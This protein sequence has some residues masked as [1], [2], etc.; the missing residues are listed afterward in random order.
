M[1]KFEIGLEMGLLTLDDVRQFLNKELR[2][3]NV[4][5][6]YTD[7]YLSLDKGQ[8]EVINTIFYN[9]Q[10]KYVADR[11]TESPVR[12]MLIGAIRKKWD[13]GKISTEQC[14]KYLEKLNDYFD[15][16]MNCATIGEYYRLN[17]SGS[18]SDRDFAAM[19]GGILLKGID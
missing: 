9:L 6:L 19:L 13:F 11:S 8:E 17:Q 10:E 14:V 7:V 1:A 12:R 2:G 16:D 15:A 4:P 18:Y 3:S 5:Y